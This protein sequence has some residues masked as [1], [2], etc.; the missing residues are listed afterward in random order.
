MTYYTNLE[1]PN[2]YNW[3]CANKLTLNLKKTKYLVFQPRQK[4]N[5]N[6]LP[7][8]IL[9][10]EILEKASNIKYLGIVIDHLLSWHD[11]IDYVCDKVSRSTD[12]MTEVK[13]YL[14]KHCLISIDYS[15]VYSYLT[16]GCLLWGNT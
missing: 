7:P 6:L 13:C 4:I 8:L 5:F 11:H 14:G 3:L 12:I 1:L 10:G 2:I 15:L 16:Y 9:A